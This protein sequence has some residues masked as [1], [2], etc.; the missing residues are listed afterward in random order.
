VWDTEGR[1]A[2]AIVAA[3][4]RCAA[5]QQ[6]RPG[7]GGGGRDGTGATTAPVTAGQTAA[8]LGQLRKLREDVPVMSAAGVAKVLRCGLLCIMHPKCTQPDDGVGSIE[9]HT[10]HARAR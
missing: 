4:L 5:A 8:A 6:Q 10:K 1:E 2:G 7:S 9:E 3:V